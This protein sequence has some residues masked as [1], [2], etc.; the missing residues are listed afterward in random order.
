MK[1]DG[2][3]ILFILVMGLFVV[4]LVYPFL[5]EMGHILASLLVGAEVLEL[6][7][8]PI[9]SVLCN[10]MG[11][12]N[13]G[14]IIIGFGGTML[15]LLISFL[16]PRK[17]FFCWYFRSLLQGVSVLALLIS[18]ASVLFAVNPQ[19][20]MIQILNFWGYGKTVLLLILSGGAVIVLLSIFLDKPIRR[21]C[22]Y[23]GV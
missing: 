17:W 20:D 3:K 7:L 6:T 16:I 9:P 18:C 4:V 23:F 8:F 19:D 13:T 2:I 10:V 12:G 15:P 22:Q 11:I 5:H 14:L 1:K 21:I